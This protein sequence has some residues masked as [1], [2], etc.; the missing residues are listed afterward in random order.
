MELLSSQVISL[1]QETT[2]EDIMKKLHALGL[3]IS[4]ALCVPMA[5]HAVDGKI[6]FNGALTGQTCTISPAGGSFT[7]SRCRPPPPTG[8]MWPSPWGCWWQ[9][10]TSPCRPVMP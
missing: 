9:T 8:S 5:A 4:A 6:T 3:A 10:T 2:K 7:A 1:F